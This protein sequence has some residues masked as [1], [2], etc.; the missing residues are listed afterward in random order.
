VIVDGNDPEDER[1]VSLAHEVGHFLLDYLHPREVALKVLGDAIRE[2]LDGV[3]APT[4]EERLTG[5]LRGVELGV[6]AHLMGRSATGEASRLEIL[7]AE[8]RADG[9]ALELLA[10]RQAVFERLQSRRIPRRKGAALRA[11]TSL[12]VEEFGLPRGT[13]ERYGRSIITSRTM[14]RSFREWLG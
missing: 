5:V 8:D 1:R 11:V 10:P 14:A 3:R 12:L 2:V 4:L 9:F 7:K 6:Y 13:G